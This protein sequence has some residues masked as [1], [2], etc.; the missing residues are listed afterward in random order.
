[1][2]KEIFWQLNNKRKYYNYETKG[3]ILC[4]EIIVG[5]FATPN[6]HR[7]FEWNEKQQSLFIESI[8]L[9]VPIPVIYLAPDAYGEFVIV[10]GVQ[11][12]GS[13]KNFLSGKLKLT[14]LEVLD[15][16]NGLTFND[17]DAYERREFYSKMFRCVL[18]ASNTDRKTQQD[19]YN[20]INGL[21]KS[22]DSK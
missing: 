8:L 16:F 4:E 5:E 14:G 13:L 10:D 3:M 12:I 19:L 6:W 17:L 21:D 11:R 9:G 15:K 1:M 18:F 20:R 2:E 22:A 7:G